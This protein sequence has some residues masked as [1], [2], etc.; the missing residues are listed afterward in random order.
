MTDRLSQYTD[1]AK[2]IDIKTDVNMLSSREKDLLKTSLN[3]DWSVPRYKMRWF[4]G[5]AQ[6]TKWGVFRQYMLEMR[7][8]EE[9]IEKLN[10]EIDKAHADIQIH[11]YE[12]EKTD[13]P[14]IRRKAQIE[15]DHI[16]RQITRS[17]RMK[18]DAMLDR[19]YYLDLLTDMLDGADG[20]VS[21]GSGRTWLDIIYSDEQDKFEQELWTNRLG[22]QAALDILFYGRVGIG[23]MDAILQ[24]P[25]DQQAETLLLATNYASE[26]QDYQQQ[27]Q[28]TAA[29]LKAS[30]TVADLKELQF[31][32]QPAQ[33]IQ[34][35]TVAKL[36]AKGD[37]LDVYND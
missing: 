8:R 19:Q 13:N 5:Q 12:I 22:K 4:Q 28:L 36:E 29:G 1:F 33:M 31:Q 7:G 37:D 32:Q 11:E 30:G 10:Y 23:N 16:K 6:I 26:L 24:M 34:T 3:K 20:K 2:H 17:F 27:L 21:D 18:D 9:I 35:T 14:G 25:E 15:I